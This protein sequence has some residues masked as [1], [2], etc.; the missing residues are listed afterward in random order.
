MK[1]TEDEKIETRFGAC[2]H[3]C[4]DACSMLYQVKDGR[5]T[6]V[7]GNPDH[8]F[9]RG[10]LCVKIKDFEKHHYNGE[11]VLYPLRRVGAKGSGKFERVSWSDA[12]TEIGSKWRAIIEKYGA[13]A[14][15]PYGYA[16]NIGVLNGMNAG[17]AFFN[18]LGSTIPEKTI[19]ASGTLSAQIL[20]V[21]PT[22]GIDP[23][24][25]A[26]AK[27]IVL[28]GSNTLST[29]SH[30]WPFI[31]K[32]RHN[33]A[34]VVVIDPYRSRTAAQADWHLAIKPG[35]DGLLAMAMAQ[36]II[37][38][39]LHDEDYVDRYTNGFEAFSERVASFSPETVAETVGLDADTIRRFAREYANTQP[40]A[41]K[42]GVGLERHPQGSQGVRVIDCLPA[43]VGAWRHL[44]GGL[45]QMTVF[46][47]VNMDLLSRPEWINPNSRILNVIHLGKILTGGLAIDP[48]VKSMFIW[49]A[50][51]AV[52]LP[53]SRE[54]ARGLAREDLFT[55][56]SELFISDTADYA[57]LIL[58]ATM[59][60][61]HDDILTSWGHFYINLNQKA[62]EPPGEA[63]SNS[64]LFRRLAKEMGMTDP[65]F[66][67][68]D[69]QIMRN[70]LDW[71]SP[72]L[73]GMSFETLEK[74]GYV[75]LNLPSADSYVPHAKGDFPTPSG[76]C[77]FYSSRASHTD[78][79]APVL[80]QMCDRPVA[81]EIDPLVGF[82]S[83]IKTVDTKKTGSLQLLSPKSHA[84]L[85][86]QH[87]NEA[88]KIRAQGPQTLLI[89]PDDARVRELSEGNNIEIHNENGSFQAI[90]D[91]PP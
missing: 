61:E 2:P 65:H 26:H 85:N 24:S 50:N 52:H 6:G 64:E 68:S 83:L 57:D 67:Q 53:D 69:E 21:G 46:V 36:V 20:T 28:W 17:D 81:D 22:L 58:P 10:R 29:H 51:P 62:I 80:R 19:C 91:L 37:E 15:L 73:Q 72:L 16:G 18:K 42:V 4:P 34:K 77:E 76:K 13:Q 44:G 78:F 45:S 79:V 82:P 70:A 23:E 5:L 56:V 1:V 9:T 32:A 89:H 40:S 11:R 63:V 33:G 41:I 27:Y 88:R 59:A 87:A 7:R 35:T 71:D 43:L 8:G 55:V 49:N 39:G 74:Q 48:P 25:F 75:R 90:A 31:L 47:P 60:A 66:S 84:F 12:L 54:V 30:L 3:D 86:S 38:E 14:I